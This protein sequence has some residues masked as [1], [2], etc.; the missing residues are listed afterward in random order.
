MEDSKPQRGVRVGLG[1]ETIAETDLR[2][3]KKGDLPYFG[4]HLLACHVQPKCVFTSCAGFGGWGGGGRAGS[5][6]GRCCSFRN[7]LNH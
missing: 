3:F 5:A 2:S 6:V 4:N 7:I 1:S